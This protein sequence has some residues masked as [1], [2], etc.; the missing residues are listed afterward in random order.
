MSAPSSLAVDAAGRAG[1]R[2]IGF[3]RDDRFTA[4]VDPSSP[5]TY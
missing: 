1:L 4:Y 5:P 3:A 2:L